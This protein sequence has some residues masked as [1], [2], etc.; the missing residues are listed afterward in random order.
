MIYNP[1]F[2]IPAVVLRVMNSKGGCI[3][4]SRNNLHN[5]PVMSAAKKAL[6]PVTLII[7]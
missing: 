5:G 3:M 7:S 1:F 4:K 2:F 6:E